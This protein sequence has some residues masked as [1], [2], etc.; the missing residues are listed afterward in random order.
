MFRSRD[1]YVC[2]LEL[3][4]NSPHS[5]GALVNAQN[6]TSAAAS[7]LAYLA[8]IAHTTPSNHPAGFLVLATEQERKRKVFVRKR[9]EK[10]EETE[11]WK[12]ERGIEKEENVKVKEKKNSKSKKE[13]RKN[14]KERQKEKQK[15][16]GVRV[17]KASFAN[18]KFGFAPTIS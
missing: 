15:Q 13:R 6:S 1:G 16:R 4:I 9:E 7:T 8:G 18:F 2:V 14:K 17:E 5:P 11:E 3:F 12:K 10:T